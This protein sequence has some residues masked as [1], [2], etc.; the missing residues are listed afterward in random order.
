MT[1]LGWCV[2]A[3]IAAEVIAWLR[4]TPHGVSGK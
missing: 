1:R 4:L 2:V 3:A